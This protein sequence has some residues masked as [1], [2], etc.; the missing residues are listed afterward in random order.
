MAK[1]ASTVAQKWVRGMSGATKSMTEGANAVSVAP[2]EKAA[3]AADLY[4]ARVQE[5]VSSGKFQDNSR[6]VSLDSW[7]RSFTEKGI[8]RVATGAAQAQSKFEEFMAALLPVAEASS[9][10]VQ[11]MPKG[12]LE[13][14]KARMIRN[15]ENMANFKYRRRR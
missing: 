10:E 13:D 2:G 7:R 5:A 8:P 4:L 15:M 9:R 3:A 12:S 11:A 14:S 1:S 6:A